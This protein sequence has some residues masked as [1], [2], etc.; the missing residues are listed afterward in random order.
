[1][2]VESVG[3]MDRRQAILRAII[4]GAAGVLLIS[5]GGQ[6]VAAP[7]TVPALCWAIATAERKGTRVVLSGV[8]SLTLAIVGWAIAYGL[9]KERQPL[10]VLLPAIFFIGGLALATWLA[11]RYP[12]RS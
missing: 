3:M 7:I 4:G 12:Q 8:L 5:M 1:M 10:I 9:A 6:I 11:Q 2:G